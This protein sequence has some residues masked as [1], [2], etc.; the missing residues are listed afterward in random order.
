MLVCEQRSKGFG[1]SSCLGD[2]GRLKVRQGRHACHSTR[3]TAEPGLLQGSNSFGTS[4]A[5]LPPRHLN[6]K[7]ATM[8]VPC[9]S[10]SH[11]PKLASTFEPSHHVLDTARRVTLR[12]L[13]HSCDGQRRNHAQVTV[14]SMATLARLADTCL[15]DCTSCTCTYGNLYRNTTLR[16]IVC[17][18]G[19][20]QTGVGPCLSGTSGYASGQDGRKEHGRAGVIPAPGSGIGE[21]AIGMLDVGDSDKSTIDG[22]AWCL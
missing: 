7:H 21:G 13:S 18:A 16:H 4:P 8:L 20:A 10:S 3:R 9:K 15:N 22:R 11:S 2:V 1:R 14:Q 17:L 5:R 12:S 19:N 6:G